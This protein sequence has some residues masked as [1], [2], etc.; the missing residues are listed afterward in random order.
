MTGTF[1]L[2]DPYYNGLSF[3]VLAPLCRKNIK[4]I[5]NFE[6]LFFF[7]T[8][9]YLIPVN[10]LLTVL[11]YLLTLPWMKIYDVWKQYKKTHE[12]TSQ[13]GSE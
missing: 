13:Q 6:N 11:V 1:C 4:I 2:K 9:I 3:A 7:R 5:P 8:E 12:T 10:I